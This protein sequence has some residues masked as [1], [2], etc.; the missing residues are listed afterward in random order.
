MFLSTSITMKNSLKICSILLI[1]FSLKTFAHF[2]EVFSNAYF[3]GDSLSDQGSNKALDSNGTHINMLNPTGGPPFVIAAPVGPF[4]DDRV[5]VE[6]FSQQIGTTA[7]I[8]AENYLIH[9]LPNTPNPPSLVEPVQKTTDP[10]AFDYSSKPTTT[11]YAYAGMTTKATILQT[12][13]ALLD[14]KVVSAPQFQ[15]ILQAIA[16]QPP[17]I[18]SNLIRNNILNAT[19]KL[20]SNALYSIWAGSNDYFNNET[21]ATVIVNNLFTSISILRSAGAKNL[22]VFNLPD[23]SES[24]GAIDRLDVLGIDHKKPLETNR[25]ILRRAREVNFPL[26]VVDA[27]T[28]LKNIRSNPARFGFNNKDDIF[29]GDLLHPNGRAHQIVASF[30]AN[31]LLSPIKTISSMFTTNS[32]VI[33]NTF[34]TISQ[35]MVPSQQATGGDVFLSGNIGHNRSSNI[36]ND[37][38]KNIPSNIT[39][40]YKYRVNQKAM[41]GIAI[42][43]HQQKVK[44]LSTNGNYL[45][46]G[47]ILSGYM[48][49]NNSYGYLQGMVQAGYNNY[50][51]IRRSFSLHTATANT[52]GQTHGYH[53]GSLIQGGLHY[54]NNNIQTGPYA[55]VQ[56]MQMRIRAYKE[57]DTSGE[58]DALGLDI[59]KQQEHRTLLAVGWR[60]AYMLQKALNAYSLNV[61]L[62]HYLTL[63]KHETNIEYNPTTMSGTRASFTVNP[64]EAF[65]KADINFAVHPIKASKFGYAIGYSYYKGKYKTTRHLLNFSLNMKI[66]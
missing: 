10:F 32:D 13:I 41:L 35:Q 16:T 40:G 4:T 25:E 24:P 60:F 29:I 23:F 34:Q 11:N 54:S 44:Q 62:S 58:I 50:S 64:S 1:V 28:L 5:W 46:A 7:N 2:N 18:S 45:L 14:Q 12:L 26:L 31:N 61:M 22:I 3:F 30:L 51:D 57:R 21:D 49:I 48:G 43:Q 33:K 17:A 66:A 59:H 37:K 56:F 39:V 55:E 53:F 47:Q 38:A 63:N 19:N 52:M 27:E 36:G 8:R 20:D 9:L 65:V 15:A 6:Y 42:S